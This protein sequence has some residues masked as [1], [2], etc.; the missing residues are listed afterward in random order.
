MTV[1]S[2]V[3]D[4]VTAEAPDLV[5]HTGDVVKS[6]ADTQWQVFFHTSKQPPGGRAAGAGAG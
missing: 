1:P 2:G 3:I 5:V 6:G 4:A